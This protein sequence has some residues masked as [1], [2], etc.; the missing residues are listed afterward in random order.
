MSQKSWG[1]SVVD[2]LGQLGVPIG[3]TEQAQI[4]QAKEERP[5]ATTADIV[6]GLELAPKAMVDRA[7][8]IAKAEG[9]CEFLMDG[10]RQARASI[11]GAAEASQQLA[12]VAS[13]IAKK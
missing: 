11:K 5:D 10:F 12:R 6:L 13:G 9:S 4:A 8:A 3:A 2:I 7:L 1:R